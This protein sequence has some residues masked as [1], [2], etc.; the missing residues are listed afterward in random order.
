MY[1]G[2]TER[3]IKALPSKK[4]EANSVPKDDAK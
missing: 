3:A 2:A 4:F 1:L